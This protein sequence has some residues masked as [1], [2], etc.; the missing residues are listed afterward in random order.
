MAGEYIGPDGRAIRIM[1]ILHT[2]NCNLNKIKK[3]FESHSLIVR[4]DEPKFTVYSFPRYD[5]NFSIEIRDDF[6]ISITT[7]IEVPEVFT[8][9][10]C[11]KLASDLSS[12]YRTRACA[13]TVSIGLLIQL[14]YLMPV[15]PMPSGFSPGSLVV[16]AGYV[17]MVA[18]EIISNFESYMSRA[19]QK[20]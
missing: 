3:V 13:V 8:R 6:F 14:E 4:K 7:A 1:K 17:C 15:F 5:R 18:N 16:E 9:E 10:E 11:L 20:S 2:E 12:R 19:L